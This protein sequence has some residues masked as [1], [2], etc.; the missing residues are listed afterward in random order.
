MRLF[1]QRVM[2]EHRTPPTGEGP[3]TAVPDPDLAKPSGDLVSQSVPPSH[4]R[5]E[6]FDCE[7]ELRPMAQRF[8]RQE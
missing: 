7:K 2:G 1:L 4:T 8:F 5:D 3:P 6:K